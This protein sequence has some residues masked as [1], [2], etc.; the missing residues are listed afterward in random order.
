MAA[1][2]QGAMTGGAFGKLLGRGDNLFLDLSRDRC[3]LY[4][5]LRSNFMFFSECVLFRNKKNV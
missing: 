1:A 3:L 2:L 5:L 4:N